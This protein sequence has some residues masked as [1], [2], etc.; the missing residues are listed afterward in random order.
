MRADA[1]LH[2]SRRAFLGSL[3]A[4]A[5]M[6]LAGGLP[7]APRWLGGRAYAELDHGACLA[8]LDAS[9]SPLQRALTVHP[10]DEPSRQITNTSTIFKRPHIDTL[11]DADQVAL[12]RR[13]YETM[14]SEQGQAW[15]EN[16]VTLEGKLGGCVLAIFSDAAPG[17]LAAAAAQGHAQTMITGGHLMLREGGAARSGYAFGGP[18]AYGQQIGNGEFRVRGNAFAAHGDALNR[19]YASLAPGERTV[20]IVAAV[21]HELMVQPQGAAGVFEGVS[22]GSVAPAARERARELLDVVLAT[23]K[24]DART[25]ALAAIDGNGGIGALR[26][27]VYAD[28]GFYADGSRYNDLTAADR[29]KRELPYWQ[30]WRIEG[31]GCVVHFKGYPHVHA[32]I[33]IVSD[34]TRQNIGEVLTRA[35]APLGPAAVRRILTA[36]MR[37]ET[38][39]PLAYYAQDVPARIGAGDVT[40]GLVR[41]IDPFAESIVVASIRGAEMADDM[42]EQAA[43]QGVAVDPGR[44]YRVATAAYWSR[45]EGVFGRP[46]RVDPWDRS[47]HEALVTY[48]RDRNLR[49][50]HAAIG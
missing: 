32:Y 1:N 7:G 43:V 26:V 29:A 11:F 47:L 18:I 45:Q 6:L 5:G 17:E 4:G 35:A 34:P 10:W 39:L 3:G 16:T 33:N 21:P 24:R 38:E 36:A 27:A 14:L 41:A 30:V 23:Y 19:F 48:L 44:D 13:L 15:L 49:E 50:F 37:Q 40:V 2:F 8:R 31:P 46:H 9:L 12:V 28:Y 20:S 25:D 42:R 22:L